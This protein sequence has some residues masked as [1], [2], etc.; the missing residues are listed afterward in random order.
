MSHAR[1]TPAAMAAAVGLTPEAFISWRRRCLAAL[2]VAIAKPDPIPEP[3]PVAVAVS[4]RI[5]AERLF[6]GDPGTGGKLRP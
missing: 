6:E 5:V 3:K 2:A 4:P 1:A